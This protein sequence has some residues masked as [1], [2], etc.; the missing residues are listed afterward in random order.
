IDLRLIPQLE[1]AVAARFLEID[2][3]LAH[4]PAIRR[5]CRRHCQ[6]RP[7]R[8][9]EL[10]YPLCQ[11][12]HPKRLAQRRQHPQPATPADFLDFPQS[13][14]VS[15]ADQQYLATILQNLEMADDLDGVGLTE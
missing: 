10:I 2:R 1:P 7:G 9:I 13:R 12:V 11:V 14:G 3:D 4:I 5:P 8:V 15:T 6:L